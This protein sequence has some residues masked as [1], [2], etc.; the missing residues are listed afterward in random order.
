MGGGKPPPLLIG[1]D[2]M[3]VEKILGCMYGLA[4]GDALG[5]PVEFMSRETIAEQY[6]YLD[7]MVG[8]GSWGQPAGTVSDDTEMALAVAEGIVDNPNNPV[9][10]I[11]KRFLKWYRGKPFDVGICC[12]TVLNKMVNKEG[13]AKEWFNAAKEYDF[14]SG[15]M[16]G[17]NGG[18]MRTAYVGCYYRS[19]L[20]V[21]IKAF[22]VCDMTH[23]D[24]GAKVDCCLLSLMIHRL[25]DG[26]GKEDIENLIAEYRDAN[27]R[28]NIGEIEGY[29]FTVSPSGSSWNSM[30]NALRCVLMTNSFPD[31]VTMA[32]NLG[33]DTDT[34]GAI[35]GALAGTLYGIKGIPEEW[36]KAL[37][38]DV[39]YR[40]IDVCMKATI[41]RVGGRKN[42]VPESFGGSEKDVQT[43]NEDTVGC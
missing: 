33:G 39:A 40:L 12:S 42:V 8:D 38:D 34:I 4:V 7:R 32:V 2:M 11:G 16:S 14:Q 13:T 1:D 43:R 23:Y 24:A 10:E 9:P 27:G 30:A 36:K 3:K 22:D 21:E 25:V 19:P 17:G 6:G 41:N 15:G 29:P 28:Y 20:D 26:G 5:L 35:T 18:L 37:K 31:A